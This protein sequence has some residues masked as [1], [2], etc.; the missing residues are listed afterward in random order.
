[1]ILVR[2]GDEQGGFFVIGIIEQR[3][4]RGQFFFGSTALGISS[5]RPMSMTSRVFA[6]HISTQEPPI[7]VAPRWMVKV[8]EFFPRYQINSLNLFKDNIET[9]SHK[10]RCGK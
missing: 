6:A 2:V 10:R 5:G 9:I 7:S 3:R 8:M 4:N 1:M